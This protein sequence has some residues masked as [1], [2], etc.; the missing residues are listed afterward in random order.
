VV[1]DAS[2]GTAAK[3]VDSPPST[4][5]PWANG[6]LDEWLEKLQSEPEDK[7]LWELELIR[8]QAARADLQ[9][10]R[11]DGDAQGDPVGSAQTEI[12][13]ILT[14][15]REGLA[16]KTLGRH[17]AALAAFKAS[18]RQVDDLV[19]DG[20]GRPFAADQCNTLAELR[21]NVAHSI[22]E[23][24]LERDEVDT[25]IAELGVIPDKDA[26][27][28]AAAILFWRIGQKGYKKAL[29]LLLARA[30]SPTVEPAGKTA[31]TESLEYLFLRIFH[32]ISWDPETG[33]RRSS[34]P[35][36]FADDHGLGLHKS[37]VYGMTDKDEDSATFSTLLYSQD[38]SSSL[39]FAPKEYASLGYA[40]PEDYRR[41]HD[42]NAHIRSQLAAGNLEPVAKY[43]YVWYLRYN[44]GGMSF[45][46][47]AQA[48]RD[49]AVTF[50][51]VFDGIERLSASTLDP[52]TL[53]VIEMEDAGY[54]FLRSQCVIDRSI[55]KF[56][57]P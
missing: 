8:L 56:L 45:G 17:D 28:V 49:G 18:A 52:W 9:Q 23:N 22:A 37:F 43:L 4:V 26:H 5:Y 14:F 39:K 16:F 25:A 12:E 10:R 31:A 48:V 27:A 19:K 3:S 51:E 41:D 30:A 40:S 50:E 57:K 13:L 15:A 35:R 53:Q 1:L 55:A 54:R 11:R 2:E 46:G 29:E 38:M 36:D 24:H 44:F 6:G 47:C 7:K 33:E 32:S 42:I 34:D 20:C 21:V